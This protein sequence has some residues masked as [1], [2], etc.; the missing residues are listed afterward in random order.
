M[1]EFKEA[2]VAEQIKA[3]NDGYKQGWEHCELKHEASYPAIDEADIL[4]GEIEDLKLKLYIKQLKLSKLR[5][6]N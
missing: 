2:M 5:E 4:E 1:S 6:R 3:F